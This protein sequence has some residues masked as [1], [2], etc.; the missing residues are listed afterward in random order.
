MMS[1]IEFIST[2]SWPH[3]EGIV[4]VDGVQRGT[5]V[6]G[7]DGVVAQLDDGQVITKNTKDEVRSDIATRLER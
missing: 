7:G 6:D 1:K 4:R 2:G 5:W 3:S